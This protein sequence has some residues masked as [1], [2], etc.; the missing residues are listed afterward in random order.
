MTFSRYLVITFLLLC[1]YTVAYAAPTVKQNDTFTVDKIIVINHS[2]F[3]ESADNAFFI[4]HWANELHTNTRPKIIL[5]RLNFAEKDAVDSQDIAE[6]QRVLRRL[7]YIRDAKVYIAKPDPDADMKIKGKTIVV[8]TWDNWSLLPTANFSHSN[9]ESKYSLGVKEDN[10]VGLGIGTS[11]Q[12]QSNRDRKGYL[13]GV[14]APVKWV[15][16]ADVSA[17]YYDNSDGKAINFSFNKPFY[18]LEGTHSYSVDYNDEQRID[19]I[20]QNGKDVEQFAHD[21]HQASI[22][23]GWLLSHDSEQLSR[24]SV[25]VTQDKHEFSSAN[26]SEQRPADR[27]FLYPWVNYQFIQDDFRVLQNVRLIHKNEDINLGWQH[28]FTLGFE[29]QD[30]RPN[31]ELGYHLNWSTSKGYQRKQHLFLMNLN[32]EGHFNTSQQDYYRMNL[33]GEYFYHFTPKWIGYGKARFTASQHLPLDQLNTLGDETG[34]RGY[35]DDYQH[36]DNS[37]LATAEIRYIPN[38]N[39]YQLADLGW[40]FFTDVG[41]TSGGRA[42]LNEQRGIIGSVGIGARLYSSK[43]SY[44]NVAHIDLTYPFT[45]GTDVGGF[46]WRF[47]VRRQF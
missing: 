5:D 35:P 30:T 27:D 47:E 19:T 24:I 12:Y 4:H 46:E 14:S 42:K 6:A 16:H 39:L 41:K 11:F 44:G 43:A 17:N 33:T 3:D 40:A 7:P 36:G 26:V 31:S 1:K 28:S 32:G 22:N 15:K 34:V 29:T 21:I 20:R 9:G 8:E 25:G 18:T 23:Y 38:V 2:I 10:L 45:S 37:W 13:F